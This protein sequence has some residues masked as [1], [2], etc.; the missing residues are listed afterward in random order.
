MPE[1]IIRAERNIAHRIIEEFMIAANEAVARHLT[2]KEFPALYR[3]HEGPEQE[4]L[5]ALAPFLLSLG[6]RLPQKKEQH[7]AAGD[8]KTAR[9][10]ARQTG[11]ESAQ[12]CSLAIDETSAVPARKHRPLRSGFQMLHSF[13]FADPALSRFDRAPDAGQ[14]T[15]R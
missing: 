2:E 5:E 9:I 7:R 4:A 14:S 3:V 6:Y 10:G 12:S 11:R 8:T 1:N 15:A 13:H